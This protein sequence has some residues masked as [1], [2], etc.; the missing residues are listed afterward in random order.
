M[1]RAADGG[2]TCPFIQWI[3]HCIQWIALGSNGAHGDF[4]WTSHQIQCIRTNYHSVVHFLGGEGGWIRII[5]EV[6]F[7]LGFTGLHWIFS[8]IRHVEHRPAQAKCKQTMYLQIIVA[9]DTG[10]GA[11]QFSGY[12]KFRWR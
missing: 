2:G 11:V 7:C 3:Y 1:D 5:N 12:V 8:G 6:D 4:Q 10:M 9:V